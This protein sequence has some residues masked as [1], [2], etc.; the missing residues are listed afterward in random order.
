MPLLK[1][2]DSVWRRLLE[3]KE[4]Y[5][6][7]SVEEIVDMLVNKEYIEL[8]RLRAEGAR[9]RNITRQKP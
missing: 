1:V 8:I 7:D 9:V 6:A 5:K 2:K 4:I 3:L